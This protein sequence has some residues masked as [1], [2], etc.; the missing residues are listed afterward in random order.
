M[1]QTVNLFQSLWHGERTASTRRPIC[2]RCLG[3]S[4]TTV[5]RVAAALLVIASVRGSHRAAIFAVMHGDNILVIAVD[6]LRAAALGAYGNTTFPTPALDQ[7][8]ADSIVFD[9]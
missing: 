2:P 9:W 5:A 7:F 6:G 8:A 3:V 4:A 1:N